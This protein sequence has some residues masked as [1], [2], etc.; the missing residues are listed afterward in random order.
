MMRGMNKKSSEKWNVPIFLLIFLVL[1]SCRNKGSELSSEEKY[2]VDTMYSKRVAFFRAEAD[3]LC[4]V[5]YNNHFKR[6][7][8]SIQKE[9]LEEIELLLN[10]KI[11]S[12]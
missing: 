11:M 12:E 6:V 7:R 10:K 4:L 1:F 3:S 2:T 5:Y 9:T 8:D